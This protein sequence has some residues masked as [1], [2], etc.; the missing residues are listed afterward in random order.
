MNDG[1][2]I[3]EDIAE[4]LGIAPMIRRLRVEW[5]DNPWN[6]K[7]LV[8]RKAGRLD[9]K[10]LVW[11]N[12]AFLYGR[13]YRLFQYI[14]DLL[15]PDFSYD[16]APPPGAESHPAARERY[17]QLWS[18]YVD[19]RMEKKGIGNFYDRALR[20]S[21][22]VE[23]QK[24]VPWQEGVAIF[25]QL[26]AKDAYTHEEIVHRAYALAELTD[27]R[28][29]DT[30][31]GDEV[32]ISGFLEKHSVPKHLDKLSSTRL[33]EIA[34][35]LLAYVIS[36]KNAR[37]ASCYY[38]ISL[39]HEKRHV[40]EIIPTDDRMFLTLMD[41]VQRLSTFEIEEGADVGALKETIKRTLKSY[42][43]TS[44]LGQG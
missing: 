34:G 25:N 42:E 36:Y 33:Q 18:I 23:G 10:L 29:A 31:P 15:D 12:P 43:H 24:R 9:V 16:A 3:A 7:A 26:W 1:R 8:K 4:G 30:L 35:D 19:S 32:V 13:I 37:I 21:L 2:G 17:I 44:H 14:C 5:V 22:F 28:A 39:S 20:R 40:G 41:S 27:V 11:D 38:G 6:E